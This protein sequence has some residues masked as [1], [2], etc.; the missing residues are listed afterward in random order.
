MRQGDGMPT[1]T[2]IFSESELI[3]E[4]QNIEVA[5]KTYREHLEIHVETHYEDD[6]SLEIRI[7]MMEEILGISS[8]SNN[9]PMRKI[10]AAKTI[11]LEEILKEF[12]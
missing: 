10:Q 3:E 11:V 2:K 1:L 8:T 9:K 7:Q 4:R 12:C 6:V 5:I